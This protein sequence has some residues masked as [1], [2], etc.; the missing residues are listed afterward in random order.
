MVKIIY[1]YTGWAF[2]PLYPAKIF[3]ERPLFY[4]GNHLNAYTLGDIIPVPEY[5]QQYLDYE[6]EVAFVVGEP[7]RNF[8]ACAAQ[9]AIGGYLL[10]ND[11]T[12]RSIQMAEMR[13]GFG[14][15]K[16]KSF[17]TS[18]GDVVVTPGF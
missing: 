3:Y 2:P 9:H 17:A 5:A 14:I 8:T 13:S 7:G 6:L 11:F 4:T 18:Y 12:A 1:R 10:I 16:T 15:N